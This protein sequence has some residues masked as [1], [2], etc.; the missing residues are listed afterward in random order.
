[1][2]TKQKA[3]KTTENEDSQDE[4]NVEEENVELLGR[5]SWQLKEFKQVFRAK[6]I[7]TNPI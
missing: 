4:E 7:L 5:Y 3:T 6:F 1:M 2:A